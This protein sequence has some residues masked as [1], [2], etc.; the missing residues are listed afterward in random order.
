MHRVRLADFLAKGVSKTSCAGEKRIWKCGANA[1]LEIEPNL[2]EQRITDV[3]E[4]GRGASHARMVWLDEGLFELMVVL[5]AVRSVI[6]TSRSSAPHINRAGGSTS[7]RIRPHGTRSS[8][9]R[10]SS[11]SRAAVLVTP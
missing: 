1:C 7:T 4:D 11:A 6:R 9:S 5:E 2:S 3:E 10:R 8:R